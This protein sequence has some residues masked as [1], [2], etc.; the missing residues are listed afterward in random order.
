MPEPRYPTLDEFWRRLALRKVEPDLRVSLEGRLRR[1]EQ[2]TLRLGESR[3]A[4][5]GAIAGRLLPGSAVPAEALAAFLDE[6]FDRPLGRGDERADVMPTPTLI[7]T[8]LDRIDELA[9]RRYGRG[10]AALAEAERDELLG[11]AERGELAAGPGFDW[12][13]WFKRVRGKLLL[14]YG[15]DPRG[16]V[17]MGFPGPSYRSG[18]VW[19]GRGEVGARAKRTPGY[20]KL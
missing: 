17:Q 2:G 4:V 7:P 10:F 19:L 12:T 8:G 1:E 20:L 15:S 16:M 13:V 9:K 3:G 5:A 11:N 6:T 14:A 18:H